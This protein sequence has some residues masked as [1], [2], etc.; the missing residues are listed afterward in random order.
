MNLP[1][2]ST[3]SHLR[4]V[5]H[6]MQA[7]Y[8]TIFGGRNRELAEL[9][10]WLAD[11]TNPYALLLAPTGRG[12]TALVWHW[13]LRQQHEWQVI[14]VPISIRYGNSN[15]ADVLAALTHAFAQLHGELDEFNALQQTPSEL[16]PKLA[17]YLRRDL[18][19]DARV[20]LA[21]DGLDEATGWELGADLLPINPPANLKILL[22]A[23]D[24]AQAPYTSWYQQLNLKSANTWKY[25]LKKFDYVAL[26]ELE[27]TRDISVPDS[28]FLYEILRISTG[29][30]VIVRLLVQLLHEERIHNQQLSQIPRNDPNALFDLLLNQLSAKQSQQAQIVFLLLANAYGPLNTHD[31]LGLAPDHFATADQITQAI[32]LLTHF[33]LGDAEHGYSF[34]LQKLRDAYRERLDENTLAECN[35]RFVQYGKHA[36]REPTPYLCRFLVN[37]LRQAGEWEFLRYLLADFSPQQAWAEACYALEGSYNGYLRDL[38]LL[39]KW[40]K[41]QHDLAFSIHC[42]LILSSLRD[43]QAELSGQLQAQ[44]QNQDTHDYLQLQISLASFLSADHAARLSAKLFAKI[45]P[46]AAQSIEYCIN[47]L[48]ACP[49]LCDAIYSYQ[50]SL[51]SYRLE[52]ADLLDYLPLHQQQGFAQQLFQYLIKHPECF[53]DQFYRLSLKPQNTLFQHLS[54]AQQQQALSIIQQQT[55][56]ALSIWLVRGLLTIPSYPHRTLIP[57]IQQITSL[58]HR[59]ALLLALFDYLTSAEQA[60]LQSLILQGFPERYSYHLLAEYEFPAG[61]MP[62]ILEQLVAVLDSILNSQRRDQIQAYFALLNQLLK[63]QTPQTQQ[64]SQAIWQQLVQ[65]PAWS[66]DKIAEQADLLEIYLPYLS[67]QQ[68]QTIVDT[69]LVDGRYDHVSCDLLMPYLTPFQRKKIEITLDNLEEQAQFY[70]SEH[71]HHHTLDQESSYQNMLDKC[72]DHTHPNEWHGIEYLHPIAEYLHAEHLHL[73]Y[74]LSLDLLEDQYDCYFD[75][76]S[77]ANESHFFD[78]GTDEIIATAMYRMQRANLLDLKQ[79]LSFARY[80]SAEP[81]NNTFRL[82]RVVL[83][84]YLQT[85]SLDEQ[86]QL[87][88]QIAH[89]VEQ[90]ILAWP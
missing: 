10:A 43:T 39:Q 80:G 15:Q 74:S 63:Q 27:E 16:K 76:G 35:A 46:D 72:F 79:M 50:M 81:R 30:P 26:Q 17:A 5:L 7:D 85:L 9:N 25:S 4:R 24:I 51:T 29:E 86:Q 12:K 23:R 3:N 52:S 6:N 68:I 70:R 36:Y 37:H 41:E 59:L 28:D 11:D 69:R 58:E 56:T 2:W 32:A 54:P 33:V 83:P 71:Q 66:I 44:L 13:L 18:P 1:N 31:L 82:L 73:F 48:K 19:D 78:D 62:I 57:Y 64:I 14:F 8:T 67:Q 21:I 55:D 22:S 61:L 45:E 20:L 42:S 75:I 40:A 90:V 47:L 84:P 49:D 65:H 89:S 38:D 88:A 60:Q 87:A 34:S 77:F 53:A